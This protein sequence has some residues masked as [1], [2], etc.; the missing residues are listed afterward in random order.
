M[1]ELK[2]MTTIKYLIF[3]VL[4]G[5]AYYS[6]AQSTEPCLE[7]DSIQTEYAIHDHITFN[8]RKKCD[9]KVIISISLEKK[10][11]DSWVLFAED[12][13]QIPHINKVEIAI[14]LKE[15]EYN[16]KEKWKIKKIMYRKGCDNT[17]RFR[18]NIR[19]TNQELIST[20]YSNVFHVNKR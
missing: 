20:E 7:I 4:Q 5:F 18:Y 17:Y 3:L 13:F 11:N 12:I 10:V 2:K 6:Y 14:I 8:F 1:E 16:R 15:N 19:K 9:E